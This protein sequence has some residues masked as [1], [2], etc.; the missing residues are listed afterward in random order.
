VESRDK[1]KSASSRS[2]PVQLGVAPQLNSTVVTEA[3][4]RFGAP[5][6]KRRLPGCSKLSNPPWLNVYYHRQR[7]CAGIVG[8]GLVNTH[9][10]RRLAK[11]SWPESNKGYYRFHDKAVVQIPSISAIQGPLC[12]A[13]STGQCNTGFKSS[14][15]RRCGAQAQVSGLGRLQ[16]LG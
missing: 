3:G 6:I 13:N 15:L 16:C 10:G 12:A 7:P 8:G 14:S 9:C 4:R 1:E 5:S 11:S 2:M